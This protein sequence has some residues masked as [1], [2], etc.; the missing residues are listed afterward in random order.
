MDDGF[1]LVARCM[2]YENIFRMAWAGDRDHAVAHCNQ[3][4]GLDRSER[5]VADL[6]DKIAAAPPL[7]STAQAAILPAFHD[8]LD[9]LA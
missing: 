7:A 8:P 6:R 5:L 1:P 2:A 9:D 4:L 3:F